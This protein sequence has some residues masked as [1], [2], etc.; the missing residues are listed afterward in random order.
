MSYRTSQLS[1][2]GT[3]AECVRVVVQ[4]P[5][6][7]S[8]DGRQDMQFWRSWL[9]FDSHEGDDKKSPKLN[10]SALLGLVVVVA[11]SACFWAGLGVLIARVVR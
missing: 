1:P 4:S 2:Q 11:V 5:P 6:D 8:Q 3:N 10:W 9:E 7:D